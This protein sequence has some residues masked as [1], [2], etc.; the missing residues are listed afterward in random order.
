[1]MIGTEDVV[2]RPAMSGEAP[3]KVQC[4]PFS[5]IPHTTR[6]FSDFLYDF[7][8]VRQFY[9]RSPN[10]KQWFKDEATL[11]HYDPARRERVA[12]ILE[13]QN[14]DFGTSGRALENIARFR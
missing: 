8:K 6:L 10:F 9:P 7:P 3:V 11:L 14:R 4:L 5:Q 12:G 2:D 1:M 13:R